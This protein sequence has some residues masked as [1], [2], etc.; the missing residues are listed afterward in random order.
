LIL[1]KKISKHPKQV[2]A[3]W[4]TKPSVY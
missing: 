4:Q 2:V 3:E 1:L